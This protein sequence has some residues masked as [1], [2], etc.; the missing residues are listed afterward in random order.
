MLFSA[1]L[2]LIRTN[3]FG[4]LIPEN[5]QSKCALVL[6]WSICNNEPIY[7][8]VFI[9]SVYFYFFLILAIKVISLFTLSNEI[10]YCFLRKIP[11][12]SFLTRWARS[13]I[14][15]ASGEADL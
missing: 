9:I 4:I 13:F 1:F 7:R 10:I 11:P 3:S 14:L 15:M 6:V 2:F 12:F 5:L 8:L